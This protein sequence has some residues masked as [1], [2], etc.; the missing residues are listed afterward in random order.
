MA[1]NTDTGYDTGDPEPRFNLLTISRRSG[2]VITGLPNAQKVATCQ[3]GL[4]INDQ[5]VARATLPHFAGDIHQILH[6]TS[7]YHY[8]LDSSRLDIRPTFLVPNRL[9]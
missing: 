3:T 2:D 5:G 9:S 8:A 1:L 7:R 6:R 4:L